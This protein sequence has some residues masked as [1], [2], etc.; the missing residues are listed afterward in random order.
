MHFYL[1]CERHLLQSQ[2]YSMG[3]F[4]QKL[5]AFIG[6]PGVF[7]P[8]GAFSADVYFGCG[9]VWFTDLNVQV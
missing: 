7:L 1:R 6:D 8:D 3:A 5:L 9:F 2:P 4:I